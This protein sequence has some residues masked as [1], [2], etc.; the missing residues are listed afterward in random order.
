MTRPYITQ[1]LE[2]RAMDD[3]LHK[4]EEARAFAIRKPEL[5]HPQ[6]N[7]LIRREAVAEVRK[8]LAEPESITTFGEI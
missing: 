5:A 4:R 8:Y 2:Q 6:A 7:L 1:V 3:F